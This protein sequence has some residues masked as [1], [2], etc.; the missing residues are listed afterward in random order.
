MF[1]YRVARP[2][3]VYQIVDKIR[4][5]ISRITPEIL[6]SFFFW[7]NQN[8]RTQDLKADGYGLLPTYFFDVCLHR[9]I[10]T[11]WL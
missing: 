7:C 11:S 2:P 1:D 3:A 8:V 9:L 5:L 10:G 4:L 6:N